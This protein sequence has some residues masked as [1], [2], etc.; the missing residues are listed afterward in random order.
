MRWFLDMNVIVYHIFE[1]GHHLEKKARLFVKKKGDSKF[2]LCEYI[3][4]DLPKWVERQEEI[5]RWFNTKISGQKIE[6]DKMDLFNKDK[7]FLNRLILNYESSKDKEKFKVNINRI[8]A[9]LKIKSKLFLEKYINEFV[10]PIKEIDFE[11]FSSLNTSL[12]NISDAKT[13]ASGI[14][15]H[16]SNKLTLITADKKDWNKEN[17]EWSIPSASNLDKKYPSLPKIQYL[18]NFN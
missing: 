14:Q 9:F 10:V 12:Q 1:T 5:L 18:Q 16:Q 17:L 15:E 13:I 2:L 11:L 6:E 7:I 4:K 8:F 3:R